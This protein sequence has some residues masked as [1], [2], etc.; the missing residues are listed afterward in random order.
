VAKGHA[1]KCAHQ[2]NLAAKQLLCSQSGQSPPHVETRNPFY[3]QQRNELGPKIMIL[4]RVASLK[5]M[6]PQFAF[7]TLRTTRQSSMNAE[8]IPHEEQQTISMR[9]KVRERTHVLLVNTHVRTCTAFAQ[10]Q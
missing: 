3:F 8:E 6:I 4:F 9:S 1:Q 10:L 5:T 2:R 7:E